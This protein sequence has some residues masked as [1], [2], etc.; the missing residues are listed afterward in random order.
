[1]SNPTREFYFPM[2]RLS[3]RRRSPGFEEFLPL[4]PQVYIALPVWRTRIMA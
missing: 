1:M 4:I 2:L 3:F